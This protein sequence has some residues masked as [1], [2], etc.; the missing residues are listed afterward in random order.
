MIASIMIAM[1]QIRS[2]V[3]ELANGS[4]FVMRSIIS[5]LSMIFFGI[6]KE[7]FYSFGIYINFDDV[8]FLNLR[9]AVVHTLR[10]A[11]SIHIITLILYKNIIYYY[12]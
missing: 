3:L 1:D 11:L 7:N 4:N 12:M 5:F 6:Y 8:L 9:C 2:T 10:H